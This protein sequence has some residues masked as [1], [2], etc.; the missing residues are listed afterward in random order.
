M[1]NTEEITLQKSGLKST[2]TYLTGMSQ[3]N[4]VKRRWKTAVHTLISDNMHI[5]LKKLP[6]PEKKI[7]WKIIQHR[8]EQ[9]CF[10]CFWHAIK[11]R[12]DKAQSQLALE[13]YV[14]IL[15]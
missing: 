13:R 8:D 4:A 11:S 14:R 1:S 3:S 15:N 7:T 10:F 5:I 2:E 6:V 12:W 9:W